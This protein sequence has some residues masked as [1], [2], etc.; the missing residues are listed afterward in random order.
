MH[1]KDILFTEALSA[2]DFNF[3]MYPMASRLGIFMK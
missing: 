1:Q 3:K 2:C